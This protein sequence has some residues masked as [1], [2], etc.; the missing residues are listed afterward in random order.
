M[1]SKL[2]EAQTAVNVS[3]S[4]QRKGG[5]WTKG[6]EIDLISQLSY[7]IRA[8]SQASPDGPL[9][10]DSFLHA[11]NDGGSMLTDWL[12]RQITDDASCDIYGAYRAALQDKAAQETEFSKTTKTL[13]AEIDQLGGMLI[14]AP[15]AVREE[16]LVAH[17]RV[18][19]ELEDMR[20]T[21][22]DLQA[23]TERLRARLQDLE[24]E[25]RAAMIG[26]GELRDIAQREWLKGR[27]VRPEDVRDSVNQV[28]SNIEARRDELMAERAARAAADAQPDDQGDE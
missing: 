16:M 6:D 13:R 9:Y 1:A 21:A 17:A 28:V 11:I 27:L 8:A 26:L 25:N 3:V 2:A 20:R 22:A 15:A 18:D 10:L 4:N 24:V 14:T 23:E 19:A 7:H 12:T 5:R